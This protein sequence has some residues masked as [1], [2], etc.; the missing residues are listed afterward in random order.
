M[1]QLAEN[2]KI[3]KAGFVIQNITLRHNFGGSFLSPVQKTF[4]ELDT[5]P[6]HVSRYL[7]LVKDGFG[8]S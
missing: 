4:T 8:C 3:S 1:A 2:L 7:H 5:I 6:A